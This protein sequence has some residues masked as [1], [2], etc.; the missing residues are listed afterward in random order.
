MKRP[1][2]RFLPFLMAAITLGQPTAFAQTTERVSVNSAGVQGDYGG[3]RTSISADG[4]YV[5]FAS[6]SSNLAPGDTNGLQDVFVHDRQTGQTSRVSVSSAGA[7]GNDRST[8]PSISADG[9]W[10]AFESYA[11]NLVFGDTN[12]EL[13]VFIHDRLS[14]QTIRVSVDSGGVQGNDSSYQASVSSDGR[15]TAFSSIATN[16]VF[17]DTNSEWDVF[18]HDRQTGQ[19]SR[20][21][22]DSAGVQGN[23]GGSYPSISADGIHVAFESYST[24]LVPGDTNGKQD[25]FVHDRLTGQTSRVTVDS[26]GVQGNDSSYH[27]S[28]SADSRYTT[29]A[30]YA[31]NLVTGDTNADQDVFVHD[32]QTG[33][34][35]RVSVD[36]AGIQ[37]NNNSYDP[38]ISSD[39]RYVAFY[40]SA[41]NLA[42][43]DT[44]SAYDVFVHDRQTSLTSRVSLTSAGAQGNNNSQEPSISADGRFVAFWS[45]ANNLVPGD[46]NGWQ[47]VFVHDRGA[48]GPSLAKNGTCPGPVSLTFGNCT[49]GGSVAILYGPAGVYTKPNQPCAGLVLGMSPPTLGTVMT[50]NG[51]GAGT[52][53]FSAPSGAC[54][55]TVQGVDVQSCTTTNPITL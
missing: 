33:Q 12:T 18:V 31:T 4:R 48:S 45:Y 6:G 49:P 41:T 47:D 37:G 43:G 44:N 30:S 39:G 55:R 36:S 51:N 22:V 50:A 3:D 28:I 19:T 7:Q 9:R 11:S 32:S 8:E 23:Y 14:G 46:T 10:V 34:T 27:P 15:Y 25:A 21:T 35:S 2:L 52:L 16:F 1:L 20:V 13:D 29:F 17:S 5:A 53:N 42:P 26:A 24:N 38:S 40:G 54:G